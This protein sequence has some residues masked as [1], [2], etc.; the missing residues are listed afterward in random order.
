MKN[1]ITSFGRTVK[2]KVKGLLSSLLL[3]GFVAIS[4]GQT[5]QMRFGFVISRSSSGNGF[6]SF[7]HPGINV[8]V[9]K[10]EIDLTANFQHKKMNFSGGMVSYRYNVMEGDNNP[11]ERMGLFVFSDIKF[12]S[13]AHL[14]NRSA[15]LERR[16]SPESSVNFSSLKFSTVEGYAGFGAK[17]TVCKPL[18]VYGSIGMGGWCTLSGTSKLHREYNS[19]SLSLKVGVICSFN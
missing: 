19:Q 12:I 11:G 16:I 15:D 5:N 9:G 8:S 2:Q 7:Y 6:G 13:N 10:S 14:S 1:L 17:Y 18:Q 3:I 4:I